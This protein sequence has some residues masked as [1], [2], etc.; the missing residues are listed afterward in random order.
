MLI[1]SE[2]SFPGAVLTA[3]RIRG[4]VQEL[5][6]AHSG[7]RPPG[8][9]TISVGVATFDPDTNVAAN[10]VLE[11]ADK[12]LYMAK[13]HGRNRVAAPNPPNL[14]ESFRNVKS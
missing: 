13:Q 10:A 12:A 4:S 11:L 2:T 1:I 3:E 8:V 9:V 7:N 14:A 5:A 6:I